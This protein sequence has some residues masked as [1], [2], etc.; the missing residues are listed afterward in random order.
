MLRKQLHSDINE[1]K[2]TR[3]DTAALSAKLGCPVVETVS[4]AADG[5]AEVVKTAVA[6]SGKGQKAPYVQGD[7]DLTSKA[8]VEAAPK[9]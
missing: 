2:D 8:A 3:I 5:L 4:T 6:Q 7:V 1:K 9:A